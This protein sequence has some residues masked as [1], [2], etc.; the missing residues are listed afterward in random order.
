MARPRTLKNSIENVSVDWNEVEATLNPMNAETRGRLVLKAFADQYGIW[1]VE[2]RK[3]L[4]ENY[5]N[6]IE[7]RRGRTGGVYKAPQTNSVS[8]EPLPYVCGG[9]FFISNRS[10]KDSRPRNRWGWLWGAANIRWLKMLPGSAQ[11]FP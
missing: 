1:P 4:S 3:I 10:G 11:S 5:G 8:T 9:G 2:A 6:T 7:F